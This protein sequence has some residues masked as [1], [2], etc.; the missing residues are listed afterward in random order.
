M[1]VGP[2]SRTGVR[3]A[4]LHPAR[5][6]GLDV[7]PGLVPVLLRDLGVQEQSKDLEGTDDAYEI[8][9]L[10]LLAHALRATWLRRAGHVLTVDGYESTGGIAHSLT[11]EADRCFDR[12]APRH[13]RRRSRYSCG[14]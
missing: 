14:W 7:E 11:T 2:L 4:I 5:A 1:I 3:E 6:V 9:R 8:G 10:P 12:L 13:S